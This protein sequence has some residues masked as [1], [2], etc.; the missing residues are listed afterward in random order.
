LGS[1]SAGAPP[2]PSPPPA[3][4][5]APTAAPLNYWVQSPEEV[6]VDRFTNFVKAI[7][8]ARGTPAARSFVFVVNGSHKVCRVRSTCMLSLYHCSLVAIGSHA[9]WFCWFN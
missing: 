7:S 1:T 9:W 8:N 4:A 6:V 3:A 5:A 2:S